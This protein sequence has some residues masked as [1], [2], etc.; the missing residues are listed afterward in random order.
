MNITLFL[1]ALSLML[2]PPAVQIVL[3]PLLH[4]KVSPPAVH[5]G[6]LLT[7]THLLN[8][9]TSSGGERSCT[10]EEGRGGSRDEELRRRG[11]GVR[12]RQSGDKKNGGETIGGQRVE[13]ERKKWGWGGRGKLIVFTLMTSLSLTSPEPQL[14]CISTHCSFVF[15]PALHFVLPLVIFLPGNT[16]EETRGGEKK[17]MMERAP[18]FWGEIICH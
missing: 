13:K 4:N 2:S 5:R 12:G 7:I 3:I 15:F 6:F 1:S 9:E 17:K 18:T 8:E 10:G 14:L 11:K 16:P